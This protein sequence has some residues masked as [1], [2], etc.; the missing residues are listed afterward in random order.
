MPIYGLILNLGIPLAYSPRLGTFCSETKDG[1]RFPALIASSQYP[2]RVLRGVRDMAVLLG[3]C[4][5]VVLG[6]AL[7]LAENW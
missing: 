4:S 6:V 7:R 2:M 3:N 5:S 1:F